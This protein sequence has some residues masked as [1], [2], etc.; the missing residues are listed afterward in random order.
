[1][2]EYVRGG[3]N[4]L[5]NRKEYYRSTVRD[6]LRRLKTD[7]IDLYQLTLARKKNKFFWKTRL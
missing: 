1:M 2:R 4:Q 6:S 5:W 7:C 3:G